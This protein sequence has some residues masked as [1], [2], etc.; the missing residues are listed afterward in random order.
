[1]VFY[2]S[3]KQR[4]IHDKLVDNTGVEESMKNNPLYKPPTTRVDLQEL[5]IN[6]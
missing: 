3:L 4:V 5:G 6:K 1:M 2:V